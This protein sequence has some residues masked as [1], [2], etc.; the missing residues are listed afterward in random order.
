MP[1]MRRGF[2]SFYNDVIR[3]MR[4]VHWPARREVNRLTGVVMTV[5]F[6]VVVILTVL[7]VA[8]DTLFRVMFRGG[9]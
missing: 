2:K 5:C 8:F 4:H 3:E 7:S 9:L 6:L 1:K